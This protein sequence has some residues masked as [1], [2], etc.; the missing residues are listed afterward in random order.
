MR[1]GDAEDDHASLLRVNRHHIGLGC[2]A[3][4]QVAWHRDWVLV[5]WIAVCIGFHWWWTFQSRSPRLPLMPA[6]ATGWPAFLEACAVAVSIAL[7][8]IL[9]AFAVWRLVQHG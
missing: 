6:Y 1:Y 5:A 8:T 9:A 4:W 7:L 2:V 3:I